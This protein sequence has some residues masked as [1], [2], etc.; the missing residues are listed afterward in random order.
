MN[1]KNIYKFS[2]IFPVYNEVLNLDKLLNEW[3]IKLKKK[4]INA[5]FVI[6]EDGSTDGTK[7]LIRHLEKKYPIKN[8]SQNNRRG[9]SKAV[10]DGIKAANGEYIVCTDSD[11]QIKVNSLIKNLHLLPMKEGVLLFGFRNPRR[12]P[13]YRLIYSKLFKIYHDLL[14]S[15]KL[16]DPSC[17]FV[18]GKKETF[19][20]LSRKNLLNMKEGFW[21]GFVGESIKKKY[22]FKEISIKHY[23]RLKGQ[24]GYELS[25]LPGIIFRNMIGLIKIKFNIT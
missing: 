9:Y 17:P 19:K 4:K 18:V 23:K 15:S 14:F 6:V 11:N 20:K 8:L 7:E 3:F 13:L 1:K 2:I 21:W 10:I 22:K 12:D 25:N 24:A 16:R 5:E